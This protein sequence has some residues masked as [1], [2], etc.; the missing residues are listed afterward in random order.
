MHL[1]AD[2]N[3]NLL[4]YLLSC[5]VASLERLD[6]S[7]ALPQDTHNSAAHQTLKRLAACSRLTHLNLSA[8]IT[9]ESK[10]AASD[11]AAALAPLSALAHLRELALDNNGS[12]ITDANIQH[13][14][15]APAL[16]ALSLAACALS[17]AGLVRLAA[18]T[19][20]TRLSVSGSGLVGC[21]LVPAATAPQSNWALRPSGGSR[22]PA[23]EIAA[24]VLPVV[25]LS[26]QAAAGE[27]QCGVDANSGVDRNGLNS[28][29][30][31]VFQRLLSLDL[32]GVGLRV[33]GRQ[34][35]LVFPGLVHLR[36]AGGR[37]PDGSISRLACMPQL[38]S[39][40]L[41]RLPIG[42]VGVQALRD[43]TA[44]VRVRLTECSLLYAET[45]TRQLA[46]VLAAR[47]SG[48]WINGVL[49][50]DAPPAE[51]DAPQAAAPVADVPR[52]NAS[53]V[54]YSRSDMFG[55]RPAEDEGWHALEQ[56]H[57]PHMRIP[58]GLQI[59]TS[60]LL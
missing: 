33:S 19:A 2:T 40:D 45:Y 16:R 6:L 23:P 49:Q 51:D 46:R 9:G 17:D 8:C 20:L 57:R 58:P 1:Q 52:A 37:V 41:E 3:N 35:A 38:R 12:G 7:S 36:L 26:R 34:L 13:V 11:A 14:A 21:H 24:P 53:W 50:G 28:S 31:P 22:A 15:R 44:L 4:N 48:L 10:N 32:E 30:V 59:V 29:G 39:L 42:L 60:S 27:T 25:A 54:Q 5:S 56:S 18:L 55:L 47:G 43:S